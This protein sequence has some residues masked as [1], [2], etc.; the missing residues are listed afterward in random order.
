MS[1]RWL[2]NAVGFPVLPLPFMIVM[3]AGAFITGWVIARAHRGHEMS[4]VSVYIGALL[5]FYAGGFLQ[6][7]RTRPSD[8]WRGWS[9]RQL[10]V[11]VHRHASL[12]CCRRA[13]GRD[14]SSRP[15]R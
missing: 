5:L 9:G 3:G 7:A 14:G 1:G 15:T 11:P 13:S 10:A 4:M 6:L 8:V 12:D 2:D